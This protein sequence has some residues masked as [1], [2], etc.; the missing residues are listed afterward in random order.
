M[1][2]SEAGDRRGRAEGRRE[3]PAARPP[4]RKRS[5][6]VLLSQVLTGAVEAAGDKLAIV[7]GA[8]T[9][10][11]RELD[12]RS[13]KLARVLIDDGV[14]P[15]DVVANSYADVRPLDEYGLQ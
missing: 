9:V 7:A 2:P 11:Y 5:N 3:R 10:T 1:S 4:R 12:A 14:G 13:S 15:G 6:T 8:Q